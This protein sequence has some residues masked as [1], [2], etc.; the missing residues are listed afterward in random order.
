M[1]WNEQFIKNAIP[2]VSIVHASF[3]DT[4]SVSIDSRTVQQGDVFFALGG[5]RV[6]GH[7]FVH[8][9]LRKGAAG[10]VVEKSKK[11]CLKQCDQALL[12]KIMVMVVPD[13]RQALMKLAAAWRAQFSYPVIG[14]TGSFGKT[15]TKELIVKILSA[16]GMKFTASRG[17]QNS[18]LGLALSLFTMRAEHQVALFEMGISKRG[19]M[20]QLVA[21]AQ[22][23][24]ALI[25]AVGHA[26]MEG[27]GPIVDIAAEK[28]EIFSAFKEDNIGII[29]GDQALLASVGYKHP[30]IKF[31]LKTTNQIQA[32][33]IT[34][35]ADK[36]SCILKL[37][38]EKFPITL[39]SN[40][41]GALNNALA[42][43][44]VAHLLGIPHETIIK[45]IQQPVIVAG[46]FE[47]RTIKNK[48]SIMINDCY[49]ASPESMKAALLAFEKI[50][51]AGQKVAVLGDMLDLG[52]NSPFWH[53]QLGRFLRKV[54]S[55]NKVV[56]VG[57]LVEWTKKTIPV[58]VVVSHVATWQ[59]AQQVLERELQQNS[60]VLVK[61]SR[62][63]AL[64]NLV[65]A[66][67]Q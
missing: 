33:K 34:S 31:G 9:A 2:E 41:S 57:N 21:M 11:D 20:K 18:T 65:N 53:R 56:L 55:L 51:S 48:K 19:E 22:P 7:D 58:N 44:A 52:G 49:N 66:L 46:R 1:H 45:V 14:I 26:H 5:A 39:H 3:P 63:I 40:H 38:G 60:V 61:G 13:V 62:G 25:T 17:N 43:A 35:T 30:V 64:D 32:R 54:P 37:Y 29:N 47:R 42:A 8:D 10:L 67:A 59:E 6:D 15:S 50:D 28:R 24:I 36:T 12:K 23:T 4:V 27:L 16:H